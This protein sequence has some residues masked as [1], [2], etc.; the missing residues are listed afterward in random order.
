MISSIITSSPLWERAEKVICKLQYVIC[1]AVTLFESHFEPLF[2]RHTVKF[3][4]FWS[5]VGN[6]VVLQRNLLQQGPPMS[7][8][9]LLTIC[10]F[11]M[12]RSL[13]MWLMRV[14]RRSAAASSS[15]AGMA[16]SAQPISC[17]AID[18]VAGKQHAFG[19][20]GAYGT[21]PHVRRRCPHRSHHGKADAGVVGD[22]NHVA[23]QRQ[24]SAACHTIAVHLGNRRYA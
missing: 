11:A 23:V 22:Q 4:R 1:T 10:L 21:K 14:A 18:Q 12:S 20:L 16:S 24:V 7:S 13:P 6:G 17:A 5:Q 15:A 9:P 8:M 3:Q 2:L 19:P